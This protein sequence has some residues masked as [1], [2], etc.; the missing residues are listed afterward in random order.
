[1]IGAVGLVSGVAW[2]SSADIE[3]LLQLLTI[4]CALP[5]H[6]VAALHFLPAC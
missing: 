2:F 3:V 4:E 1:M 5:A 6:K